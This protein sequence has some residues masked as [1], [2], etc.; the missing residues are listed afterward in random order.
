MGLIQSIIQFCAEHVVLSLVISLV[1]IRAVTGAIAG[2]PKFEEYP[3]N[4][5]QEI[6]TLDEYKAVLNKARDEGKIVILDAF[7]H[8]CGP[9]RTAAPKYG[10]MSIGTR[11]ASV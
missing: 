1:V 2:Q 8:W 5:V 4:K 6:S 7:A 3:G 10:Q 11:R 9:C